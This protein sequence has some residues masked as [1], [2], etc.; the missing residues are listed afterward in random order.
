MSEKVIIRQ[1]KDFETE[2]LASD[3]HTTD[4]DLQP[5]LSI[6]HLSPYT[7]LLASIGS[8]TAVLLNSYAQNH[9]I[10]L[11]EVELSLEF[12]RNAAE[13][14]E[15]CEGIDEFEEQIEEQITFFGDLGEAEKDRLYA[16]SRQCPIHRMVQQGMTIRSRL[17]D[18][19]SVNAS[20]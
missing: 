1:N 5:A 4:S 11:E 15:D 10:D 19:T 20:G 18:S 14:C 8:C 12:G 16:V 13:D 9:G 17:V 6:Y 2:F 3:P 7:M